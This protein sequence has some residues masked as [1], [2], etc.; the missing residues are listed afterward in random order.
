MCSA[1]EEAPRD[2][3]W[4][5]MGYPYI[6]RWLSHYS[7]QSSQHVERALREYAPETAVVR[8]ARE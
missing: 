8:T 5:A 3:T 6:E 1:A 2:T 7:N 4:S